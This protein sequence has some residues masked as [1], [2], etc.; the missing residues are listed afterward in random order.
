MDAGYC[1]Y[2][3]VDSADARVLW[4]YNT[5]KHQCLSFKHSGCGGN[6]NRFETRELCEKRC[7]SDGVCVCVCVCVCVLQT[8]YKVF[9]VRPVCTGEIS[10]P[11]RNDNNMRHQMADWSCVYITCKPGSVCLQVG[12]SPP[13]CCSTASDGR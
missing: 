4:Y 1:L 7:A 12:M 3:E 13:L 10:S 9:T 11:V 5:Q 2:N 8:K 6:D